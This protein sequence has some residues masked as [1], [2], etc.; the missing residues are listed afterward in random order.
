MHNRRGS[1][2]LERCSIMVSEASEVPYGIYG[3]SKLFFRKGGAQFTSKEDF[4]L[5]YYS[6]G[7]LLF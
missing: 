2:E 7:A 4:S 1:T 3:A 5:P 6:M